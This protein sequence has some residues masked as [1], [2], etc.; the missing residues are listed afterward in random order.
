VR[1]GEGLNLIVWHLAQEWVPS[2]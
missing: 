2:S 1:R